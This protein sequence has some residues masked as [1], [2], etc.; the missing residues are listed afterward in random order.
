MAKTILLLFT[1][2]CSMQSVGENLRT[3]EVEFVSHG[4]TLSGSIVFP[5]GDIHAAVVFVHRWES[6]PGA[7]RGP[8][9]SPEMDEPR[10]LEK[11]S[12]PAYGSSATTTRASQ[13]IC[14]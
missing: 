13:L 4:T 11:L 9:T 2:L 3:E 7:W 1:L 12:M 8:S 14:R 10:A 6:R 5:A